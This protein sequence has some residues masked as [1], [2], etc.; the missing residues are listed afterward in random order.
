LG[1]IGDKVTS[2]QVT[3]SEVAVV[4]ERIHLELQNKEARRAAKQQ[5]TRETK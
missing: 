4:E 3:E 2:G 1:K 5:Q